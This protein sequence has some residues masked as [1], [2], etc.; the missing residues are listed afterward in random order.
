MED[1]CKIYITELESRIKQKDMTILNLQLLL[2]FELMKNK[3]YYDIIESQTNIKLSN[4]IK[5]SESQCNIYNYNNGKIPISIHDFINNEEVVKNYTLQLLKPKKKL[6][7]KQTNETPE[8]IIA[9]CSEDINIHDKDLNIPDELE[10]K[11]KV[12]RT[13]KKYIK[14]SEKEL[15]IK[16][17]KDVK[18]VD[19][20]IEKI[21]YNNFDVSHKE[22]TDKIEELFTQITNT[23][24]YTSSLISM[25]SLRKKLLG[26]LKLIEYIDVISF[27]IKRLEIIFANKH[28]STKKTIEIISKSL[29]P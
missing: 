28:Y 10:K 16:L 7:N 8:L 19:K 9:D 25:Q 26:K 22:I 13:V 24:G 17:Q 15:D 2:K 11:N 5:E 20:E 4:I 12:Y 6:K 21:V 1:D 29:T 3:I 27:H 23:R 18:R 14:T